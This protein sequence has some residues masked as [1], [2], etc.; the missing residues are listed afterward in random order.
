[1]WTHNYEPIAGSLGV[2]ALV[3]AIPIF[4][5]FYMLGVR[6]SP[7]YIAA[8]TALA[9]A[10]VLALV[11]YKM[12]V[13]LA[14]IS[15]LYG[16]AY[17]LFP[18]AWVV[19]ASILL[20]RIVVDT[21]K[22]EIIKSSVGGLTTDRRLQALFI[23]FSF[24]AFIEGAA[25]FG[26]PVAVSGAMLAGLGFSPFYAAGIC[27]LANTAPVAFGSIGI[28][29][30]TLAAVTGLPLLPLSAMVGRLCALISVFIP[31]YLLVVMVGW[32]RAMEVL[33]A[34]LACGISFAGVQFYVSN[35]MGPE[36]TDILSSLTCII[37]MVFVL[38]FWKP[39]NILRLP[40]DK[41]ITA[42]PVQHG[43][44]EVFMAW[45]PY[46]LLVIFVLLW[47]E[48][49]VKAALDRFSDGFFPSFLPHATALNGINVPGLH[50]LITRIPPV[51]AAP[52][53]YAAVFA[54]NWLTASG[55]ACLFAAIL[56]GA[57]LGVGPARFLGAYKA[58]L[59]QLQKPMLTIASMLGLAYLM[60]YSGMTSTLGLA[61][62]AT[63]PA[64]PFFSA[65]LGWL[66][67]FLTGSDTSSNALFG[68]LQ[69]V[70]ANATGLSPVLMASVNTAAGVMG[71]M[72]SVQSIAVAV[73]ATQMSR[74]DESRLFRFTIRHSVLLMTIMGL[75]SLLYA[76]VFPGLVP[77]LPAK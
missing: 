44:A 17:G 57:F 21:G 30:V 75:V 2:S 27:L 61:L 76:Y 46:L 65:T 68:N 73:A 47:G 67:V 8:L 6:R 48:P 54:W 11:A 52:A 38:K 51:S 9:A 25:G 34:I 39:K 29:V 10:F 49:S 63:G 18:I 62:A 72:I 20:Y 16:A 42:A 59:I 7:S 14:I 53:P 77:T 15:T 64:F 56:A 12:P 24:G 70:T 3:A 58:T 31:G 13:S 60:N 32:K 19:F 43:A 23:A 40:D 69:V 22:F 28:P 36:L 41:P 50:N 33:P 35:Y 71:K 5:L 74:D 45:M 55:T 1:M 37:V 4:V 66:G 26:T